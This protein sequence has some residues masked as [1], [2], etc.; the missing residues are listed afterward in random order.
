MGSGR[1]TSTRSSTTGRSGCRTCD[2]GGATTTPR[3][4]RTVVVLLLNGSNR[5]P[6]GTAAFLVVFLLLQLLLLEVL[7]DLGIAEAYLSLLLG[8][9]RR[10]RNGRRY[11]TQWR[12][13]LQ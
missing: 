6:L 7:R 12:M 10:F 5:R 13:I 8:R 3:L 9:D 2:Y 1:S 11:T 4:L